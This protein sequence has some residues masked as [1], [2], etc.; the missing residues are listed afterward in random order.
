MAEAVFGLIGVLIG[1]AI[2]WIK[3]MV[4][5]IKIQRGMHDV[6]TK[7]KR[8]GND[9]ALWTFLVRKRRVLVR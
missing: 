4:S 8:E 6:S 9:Y 2:S 3:E 5:E 1:S 7:A